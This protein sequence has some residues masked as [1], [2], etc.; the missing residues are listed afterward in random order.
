LFLAGAEA[1]RAQT[2]PLSYRMASS[3]DP[4]KALADFTIDED[5]ARCAAAMEG[6]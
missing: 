3:D 5:R 6:R 4:E 2:V 1:L